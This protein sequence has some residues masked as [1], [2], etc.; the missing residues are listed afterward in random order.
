MWPKASALR[1]D[2]G[3][4]V[5]DA[6]FAWNDERGFSSDVIPGF[7]LAQVFGA[8]EKIIRPVERSEILVESRIAASPASHRDEKLLGEAYEEDLE[9]LADAQV[10]ARFTGGQPALVEHSFGK[11]KAIL[12]GSFMALAYQRHQDDSTRSLS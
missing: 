5:A 7:D 2:G 10:L 12:I 4:A 11:G 3:T 8:R 9:P 6:R 1:R